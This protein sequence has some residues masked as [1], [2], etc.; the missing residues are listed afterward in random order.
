ARAWCRRRISYVQNTIVLGAGVVGQ[1]IARKLNQHP[2][3][4]LNVVGFVDRAPRERR[5]DVEHVALLGSPE[6]LPELVRM[7]DVERVVVA[8]SSDAEHE[9]VD[10]IRPLRDLDVQ[11]DIVPRLYDLVGPNVSVHSVETLPLV[12]L[13][14]ARLSRSSRLIK[15]AIDVMG[16]AAAL[17]LTSPL[18]VLFALLIRRDSPG[19]VFF[20]QRRLGQNMREFTVLKFRTM[21][22]STGDTAHREYIR[23]TMTAAAV[24]GANGL[25]KLERDDS[26]T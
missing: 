24:P 19:P 12:G 13:P 22:A 3:Y 18:F 23:G 21:K 15:R 14:P 11:I 8:F 2:E 4:G 6:R 1:L 7:L 10:L 20:R 5:A 25:Y 9:T 26:V 16:A 17:V